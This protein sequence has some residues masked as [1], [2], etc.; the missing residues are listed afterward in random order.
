M[1]IFVVSSINFVQRPMQAAIVL[2]GQYV[3]SST[4]SC[5]RFEKVYQNPIK[6]FGSQWTR[7]TYFP[8]ASHLITPTKSKRQVLAQK[9]VIFI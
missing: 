8:F 6:H 5:V 1:N 3:Q 2:F 9:H 7:Q 4:S